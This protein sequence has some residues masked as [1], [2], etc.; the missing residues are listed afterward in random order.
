M[1]IILFVCSMSAA[2]FE[3]QYEDE[4]EDDGII[5]ELKDFSEVLLEV[6]ASGRPLMLE[7]S[8]PWCEYCQ[9]LEEQVLKPM[10]V[11][12]THDSKV[13]I[14]KLEVDESWLNDAAGNE[15]GAEYFAIRHKV[16][17]YPTLVFFDGQG[18]E[19]G[20]RVV[21]ITVLD[22]ISERID[23]AIDAANRAMAQ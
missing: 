11:N 10:I 9:A 23:K 8:T 12:R 17:L 21:G 13:I 5:E 18:R 3:Y 15:V 14:R 4:P 7:F 16:N 6:K 19:I 20:K 22:Y 2:A 1:G